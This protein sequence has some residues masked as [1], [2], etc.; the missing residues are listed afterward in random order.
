MARPRRQAVVVIHGIGEQRPMDTLRSLVSGIL[1]QTT[2][3]SRPDTMS[4][5]YEL[6]RLSTPPTATHQTDFFEFYWADKVE[7][8]RL[9]HILHWAGVL[10]LRR[11]TRVPAHLRPL[12]VATWLLLLATAAVAWLAATSG[13]EFLTTRRGLAVLVPLVLAV[14]QFF[15]LFYLGDAAR[16]LSPSPR[17]VR[18]RREIREAGVGLLR[19]LHTEGAYDRI[20]LAGHS[21]G[22][23]IAYDMVRY[24]WAECHAAFGEPA[25]QPQLRLEEFER[26]LLSGPADEEDA[27]RYHA[28]QRAVWL[29]LQR[30]G[31]HWR[32][33]DLVTLGSPLAHA[34]V[35]LADD[36]RDLTQRFR[37]REL[38]TNPPQLDADATLAF[39]VEP[40][41]T[42]SRGQ[43][44]RP[45]APHHA[46]PF[47]CTR[48]T[49]LF[50]PAAFGLLGDIV[51]GA[52]APVFGAG[53]RD[54]PIRRGG[55]W[56]RTL[57]SHTRYW[58]PGPQDPEGATDRLRAALD[59]DW[60]RPPD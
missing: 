12:W 50:F 57:L 15:L 16:Y 7:G 31:H 60:F 59:L 4:G 10:L 56:R 54:I 22:S 35:L 42:N 19:R 23:V 40:P 48:W 21:L 45:R 49:N 20:V 6:R 26:L 2:V 34:A 14:P 29:E 33:T 53:V 52:L 58:R 5:S 44:V 1:P 11:W 38:P 27:S 24:Y 41:L 17:N 32:V 9:A 39:P 51:G 3:W 46:A 55:I 25:N 30:H 28:L 43:E 8:T 47:C 13:H 18:I 37:D 36:V